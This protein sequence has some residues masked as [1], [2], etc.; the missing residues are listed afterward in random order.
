M[1]WTKNCGISLPCWQEKDE[2]LGRA[3]PFLT[4]FIATLAAGFLSKG[5]KETLS[6]KRTRTCPGCRK[7]LPPDVPLGLCPECLIKAGFN[8]GTE[9]GSEGGGVQ[10]SA[11]R[12]TR[13]TFSS[14]RNHRVDRQRRH[15]GGLQGAATGV[16]SVRGAEDICRRGWRRARVLPSGSIERPGAGAAGASEHRGRA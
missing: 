8:T 4:I 15:G 10:S 1:K 5:W 6:W 16:G 9:P 7:E 13:E 2:Y 12:A 3:R 14:T 11:G